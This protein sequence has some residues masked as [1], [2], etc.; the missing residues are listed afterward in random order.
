MQI[1][2]ALG[3]S[4]RTYREH[5]LNGKSLNLPNSSIIRSSISQLEE[6]SKRTGKIKR[7]VITHLETSLIRTFRVGEE[8][9]EV[10]VP[11]EEATNLNIEVGVDLPIVRGI[12]PSM[13]QIAEGRGSIES[14]MRAKMQDPALVNPMRRECGKITR[15]TWG[16]T[17]RGRI[18]TPKGITLRSM[19]IERE[20][21]VPVPEGK[22]TVEGT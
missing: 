1:T 13:D 4:W 16:I 3:S 5:S 19:K 12:D 14:G 9:E 20:P 8:G 18:E 11:G 15:R 10:G 17:R 7:R 6:I 21:E 2:W 22:D